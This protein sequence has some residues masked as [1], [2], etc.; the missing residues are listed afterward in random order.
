MENQEIAFKARQICQ[1]KLNV[2]C[3]S[4]QF[5]FDFRKKIKRAELVIFYMKEGKEKCFTVSS[6]SYTN[7]YSLANLFSELRK[8]MSLL[9]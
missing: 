9:K 7:D 6:S 3:V 5:T 1:R 8:E 2:T 4:V